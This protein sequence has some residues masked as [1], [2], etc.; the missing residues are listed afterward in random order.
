MCQ[1]KIPLGESVSYWI[2]YNKQ[3]NQQCVKQEKFKTAY[4]E[5]PLK[6]GKSGLAFNSFPALPIKVGQWEENPQKDFG[7]H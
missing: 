7:V 1:N 2:L 4:Y 6:G 5:S 3:H